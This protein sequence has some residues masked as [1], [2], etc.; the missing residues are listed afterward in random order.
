[1]TLSNKGRERNN[2]VALRLMFGDLDE[3]PISLR[4]FQS[5]DPVYAAKVD[6]TTWEDLVHCEYL[7]LV[8][9]AEGGRVYRLTPKG[10]LLCLELNGTSKSAEFKE[11]LGR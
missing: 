6:R 11:R 4:S 10:W 7:E 2:E 8:V 5:N 9:A 3:T 1:M